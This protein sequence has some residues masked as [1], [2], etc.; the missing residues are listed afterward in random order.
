MEA[1]QWIKRISQWVWG[2]WMLVLLVG[3]GVFL[4][5]RLKAYPWRNLGFALRA[6]FQKTKGRRGSG[7]ISP[8]QS[9]MTALAADIGT[10]NIVGV[11]TA[12]Y[13]GGPGALFWMWVSA[14]FAAVVKYAE[15]VA[16]VRTRR[17]ETIPG[18]GR[19]YHGGAMYY[20]K[21]RHA[22]SLFAVLII[23]GSFFIGNILQVKAAGE[24]VGTVFG[25]PEIYT[26]SL[27]AFVCCIILVGG[28]KRISGFTAVLIPLLALCYIGA[29]LY[30]ICREASALP[31]ALA[32]VL[33]DAVS[34]A[35]V[36]IGGAGCTMWSAMRYGIT[37]GLF[38]S[39][40]GC[41]SA[42]I[43]HAEAHCHSP[44]E[45]GCYGIFEGFAL[46]PLGA[47]YNFITRYRA[48]GGR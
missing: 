45:Q 25:V 6:V 15:I 42:P 32:S 16:A 20:I 33:R 13:I 30:I 11:S 23:F 28:G 19:V 5:I 1:L 8:F 29:S 18:E 46:H 4:T 40:A 39:E 36:G 12:I 3:T 35:S 17:C 31:S 9:L 48:L 47:R 24:A 26:S 43:A 21:N 2:P 7:D 41:G 37:R 38:S 10:G 44:A 34:P 27:I 14:L 22:A